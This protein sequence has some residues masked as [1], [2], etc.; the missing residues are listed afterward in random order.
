MGQMKGRDVYKRQGLESLAVVHH[1]LHGIGL[2]RAVELLLVGLD[3]LDHGH[4][5]HVLTEVGVDV[6]HLLR[7][8]HGLLGGGVHGVTL[9]PQ[10]FPVAQEGTRGPVSYTH[11]DVYKRQALS[12]A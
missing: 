7:L 12:S 11:L 8:S 2:L 6:E 5:Q 10:E 4:G 1:A 9:L 3:A